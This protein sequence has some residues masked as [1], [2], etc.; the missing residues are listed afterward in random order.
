MKLSNLPNL[1]TEDFPGEQAW[2]SKL[3][4]QLN[5]FF[6]SINQVLD[7]NIDFSVN[8]KSVT[9]TYDITTFAPFSFSWPFSDGTPIDLR[10]IKAV[11]GS[12]QTPTI[13]VAAWQ[14]DA[15][16]K[17]ITVSRMSEINATSVGELS[18]RYQFSIR[19]TV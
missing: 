8:I 4:I 11:K 7:S 16:N 17:L 13:L 15:T 6:Q 10:V 19:A 9:R 5:P 2:I 12:V 18:G 1:R 14:Y 3:F